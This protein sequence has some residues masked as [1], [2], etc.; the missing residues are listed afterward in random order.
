[1]SAGA[2]D[3]DLL[4]LYCQC[5]DRY[6]LFLLQSG[7]L[8]EAVQHIESAVDVAVSIFGHKNNKVGVRYPIDVSF[9]FFIKYFAN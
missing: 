3:E 6:S 8:N 9:V 4:V 1:M 5:L 7:R 2:Q